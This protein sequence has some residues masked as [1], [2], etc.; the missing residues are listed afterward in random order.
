M[1]AITLFSLEKPWNGEHIAPAVQTLLRATLP[2]LKK[3]AGF[4]AQVVAQSFW[5]VRRVREMIVSEQFASPT[6]RPL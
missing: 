2:K 6:T 4:I 1:K 5:F 3:A